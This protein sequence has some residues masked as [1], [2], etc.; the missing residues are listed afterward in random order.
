MFYEFTN[1]IELE[2]WEHVLMRSAVW[3]Q[4][5]IYLGMIVHCAGCLVGAL[6]LLALVLQIA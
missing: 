2:E 6:M 4:K 5:N 3:S 1:G